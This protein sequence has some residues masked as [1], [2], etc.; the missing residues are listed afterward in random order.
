[1]KGIRGFLRGTTFSDT[2]DQLDEAAREVEVE[3]GLGSSNKNA[4]KRLACIKCMNRQI[5]CV[6]MFFLI[7]ISS[8]ETFNMFSPHISLESFQKML[9]NY[10]S[11]IIEE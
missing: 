8:L 2:P 11:S 1:M 3:E 6:M 5:S 9:N 7:F 4:S 10:N